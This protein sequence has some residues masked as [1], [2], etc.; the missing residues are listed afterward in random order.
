MKRIIIDTDTASDDAV[1]II[2]ALRQEDVRVEAVTVVAGNLP[3][4]LC[5][6][7]A[8]ISVEE[9]GTYAPPVYPGAKGPLL[10]PLFTSEF[11]HGK[12]G[13]GDMALS[14]PRL[15][16]EK[17]HAVESI[18]ELAR[19]N[20]GELDLV[21]LGPL[22]NLA[23][24]VKLEPRL[25]GL[26]KSVWIMGGQ[27]QGPGNVSPT[28]EFNLFVDAESAQI[29]LDSGLRPA[30]VGWDVSTDETFL[31]EADMARLEKGPR[32]AR[33]ALRCNRG[34][35]EHNRKDWGKIG[36]DLPDPVAMLAALHPELV[37]RKYAAWCA[38]GCKAE[39]TYGQLI[40]D[41]GSVTKRL[42][43]AEIV[44]AIDP[45]AFKDRLFETL[46]R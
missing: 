43:N 41:R 8:L 9:A 42:P 20:P 4:E 2:Y 23:L 12:D 31:G 28:A 13:M 27:G 24:A 16:A 34:L 38:V 22:T 36:F 5:I 14:Q 46:L 18:I 32:T 25:P 33:F 45:A 19:A 26:L 39:E 40:I 11:V 6:K 10:R 15:R 37:T 1:A 17:T 3:L 21:T 29:V 44:L 30:F 35:I 7:N